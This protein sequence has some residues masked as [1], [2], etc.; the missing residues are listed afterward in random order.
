LTLALVGCAVGPDPARPRTPVD[1][2]AVYLQSATSGDVYDAAGWWRSFAD[3]P[4]EVLVTEVIAGNYDLKAAVARVDEAD[5]L[6]DAAGGELLPELSLQFTPSRSQRFLDI[7]IGTNT[8]DSEIDD[9]RLAARWDL[10]L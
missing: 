10:D 2:D 3:E 7:P 8:I 9:A 1:A 6:L 5:A 4:T